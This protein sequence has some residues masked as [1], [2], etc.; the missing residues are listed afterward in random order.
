MNTIPLPEGQKVSMSQ[1]QFIEQFNKL[2]N[3]AAASGVIPLRLIVSEL[4]IASMS[5][6]FQNVQA[7]QLQQMQQAAEK[8][9][10]GESSVVSN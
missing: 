7:Y 5:L 9:K 3:D 10:T 1:E 6:V 2:I 4:Q 8:A